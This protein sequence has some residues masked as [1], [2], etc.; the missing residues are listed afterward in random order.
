ML[1]GRPDAQASFIEDI[2]KVLILNAKAKIK[3]VEV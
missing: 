3:A 2:Y 1:S